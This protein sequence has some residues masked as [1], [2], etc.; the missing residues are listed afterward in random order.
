MNPVYRLGLDPSRRAFPIED[1]TKLLARAKTHDAFLSNKDTVET[2]AKPV[3]FTKDMRWEDWAPPFINFLRS[4]PRRNG[5]PLQYAIRTNDEPDRR[6]NDDFMEEYI[7][8][9]PLNRPAFI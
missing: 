7:A 6:Q 3:K 5:V 9:A 2:L 8:M 1:V 4:Y